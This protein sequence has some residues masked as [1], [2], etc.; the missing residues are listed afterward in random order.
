MAD[1]LF[2]DL[3]GKRRERRFRTGTQC[4]IDGFTDEEL[5]ARYR[6]RRES[7]LFSTSLA[8]GDISR[9]TRRNHSLPPLHQVLIALRF[10]ASGSFLQVI[11]DTFGVDKS[12][13]SMVITD[14]SRALIVKQP[15][16][17]KWPLTNGEC[18]TIKNEFYLRGGFPCVIGCVDG[19][20][21]RLQ[22]PSQHES[23]YV[24]REGFHSINVQGV[25]NHEG[26]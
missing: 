6:F 3:H 15:R 13:V 5:H 26:E 11:G 9:N 17:I 25:S 20:H 14:V 22:A 18:A 16:F 2:C 24:N 23:N 7:I 1:L 10:Y 4:E 8:A 19:T 21:V 12:T